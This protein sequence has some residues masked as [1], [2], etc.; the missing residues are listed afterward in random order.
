MSRAPAVKRRARS[1]A[2]EAPPQAPPPGWRAL[3]ERWMWASCG[4][5][6]F[7]VFL[8]LYRVRM[9]G[10]EHRPGHGAFILAVNHQSHFDPLLAGL[11][12]NRRPFAAIARS[13][14]FS[15][16]PLARL[17]RLF[18]AVPI[19]Q[20][21]GDTAAMKA[22]L[23]TLA[24]G[25]PVLIFPEGTRSRDGAVQPFKRGVGLLIKRAGVPVLPVAIDGAH[26]VWPIGRALPRLTGRIAVIVG[27]AIPADELLG[28]DPDQAPERLRREIESLR[29]TLRRRMR[30]ASHG[31]HPAPDAGDRPYWSGSG[32]A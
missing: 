18:S 26:E 19:E 14:L 20:G 29:L 13:G 21:T 5:I 4:L 9:H 1:S 23:K 28:D 12:V 32:R 24:R 2:A 25:K 16:G 11:S 30:L 27:P 6:V 22:A 10:P 7:F 15:F 8:L 31:L 3:A 17:I